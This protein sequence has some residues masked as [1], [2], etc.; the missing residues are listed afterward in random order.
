[1]NAS[2]EEEEGKKKKEYPQPLIVFLPPF[3]P[4]FA[5]GF[6]W[7][8]RGRLWSQAVGGAKPASLFA[9]VQVPVQG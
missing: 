5:L 8:V 3:A 7:Q 4:G 2:Q 6:L 1:M 9:A